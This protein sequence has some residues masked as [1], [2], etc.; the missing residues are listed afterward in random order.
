V[1]QSEFFLILRIGG[2]AQ[3]VEHRLA[4]T[5]PGL[6]VENSPKKEKKNFFN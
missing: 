2:V 5:G 6:E 3:A 1:K 4:S